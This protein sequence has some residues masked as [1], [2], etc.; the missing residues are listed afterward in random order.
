MV[1]ET[2]CIQYLHNHKALRGK[3]DNI[4]AIKKIPVLTQFPT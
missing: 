3:K 1:H 4:M 2:S